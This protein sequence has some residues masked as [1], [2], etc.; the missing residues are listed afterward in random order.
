MRSRNRE[1][2]ITIKADN[3]A[4][5]YFRITRENI[6]WP[7]AFLLS[8]SMIGL[9]FPLGYLLAPVILVSRFKKDKYDFIIMLTLMMDGY[10]LF[11]VEDI[12]I[13]PYNVASILA[14]ICLLI[15]KKPIIYKKIILGIVAYALCLL[16]FCFLS[17]EPIISQ[18]YGVRNHLL[19]CYLFVPIAVFSGEDFDIKKLFNHLFVYVIIICWFYIIDSIVLGGYLLIPK[20]LAGWGASSTFYDLNIHPISN[21]FF[22]RTIHTLIIFSLCVYPLAKYY[23]LNKWHWTLLVLALFIS[24]TF[25]FIVAIIFVFLFSQGQFKKIWKYAIIS[26]VGFIGLYFIDS[27]ISGNRQTIEENEN[28]IVYKSS[29]LRIQSH[30]D[31]LRDLITGNLDEET[32]AAMGSS[33]GAQIV[34]KIE[35]LYDLGKEW[36]G[37]G[38]LD[39][40]RTTNQKYIIENE[41]YT[42]ISASEEVATGVEVIP[43]QIILD[44]GYLGLI[45]HILFYIYLWWIIRKLKYARY[46]ASVVIFFAIIGISGFGGLIQPISLNMVGLAFG[47]VLLANKDSFTKNRHKSQGTEQITAQGL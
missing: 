22:R 16:T 23:K 24:R 1:T 45:I 31:Q 9:H 15:I 5:E 10:S 36:V 26:V 18:I 20:S 34:P 4:K 21:M 25:A 19:I 7:L 42:D 3:T 37:F 43:I 47:A 30:V 17:D 40:E 8:L 11:S 41:L 13:K 28:G 46:A 6:L 29:V 27:L 2:E 35:L 33:R 39:R 38:F 14:L 12:Y 32:M 44:I